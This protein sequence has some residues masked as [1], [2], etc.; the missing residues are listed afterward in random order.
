MVRGLIDQL[1]ADVHWGPTFGSQL[2]SLEDVSKVLG[3][4]F[5]ELWGPLVQAFNLAPPSPG[6]IP[7]VLD[8]SKNTCKS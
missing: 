6:G 2:K 5:R 8:R 4:G 7:R 3:V 1:Y